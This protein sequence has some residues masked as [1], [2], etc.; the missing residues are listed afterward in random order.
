MAYLIADADWI[1]T[2]YHAILIW[3]K[4][5]ISICCFSLLPLPI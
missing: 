4:W 2:V 5:H 3:I 1:S